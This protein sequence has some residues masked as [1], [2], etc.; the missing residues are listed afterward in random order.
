M[1]L[2]SQLFERKTLMLAILVLARQLAAALAIDLTASMA[3]ICRTLGANR[4]SVYEQL[5]RLLAC[6]GEFAKARPGRPPAT[7]APEP[8]DERAALR[9]TVEVLEYR[10]QHPGA[11]IE[12]R[13]RT[14]YA[15][16]FR[17]FVLQRHD[18]WQGSLQA[19]ADAVQVP[20]DTLRDWR[21]DDHAEALEPQ[22]K[23]RPSVP[24]NASELT[25]QIVDEWM[26]WIGPTRP[27]I[28]YA[29]QYFDLS[30][31]LIAR[32]M[33]ILGLIRPRR[34][35]SGCRYRGSTQT[36]SPATMLVTDGKWLTL[37]LLDS[38]QTLYFNWQGIVDQT[39]G[40][41]TAVVIT[42]QEDATAARQAYER[43]VH[44]LGGLVPDALLHDNKPC[45]DD[46][47]LRQTLALYGTDMI[48]ATLGRAQNK[49]ILE[50]AFGLWQQR[51][52]TLRLD[53]TDDDTLLRSAVAEMVRVYTAATNAVPRLELDG[54]SRLQAL[55]ETCPTA[56][57]RQRDED[58]LAQ[59]KADHR[60]PRR[61]EPLPESLQLIEHVFERFDLA[62]HDP[63]GELRRYL[64]TF[65]TAA[66]RRA[67]AI[68]A[69][70]LDHHLE[71]RFAHRYLAQIIRT[72]QDELDLERAANELLELCQRQHQDWTQGEEKHFQILAEQHRD[73]AALVASVAQRAAFGGLPL[74][75]AFWNRKLLELL[76]Q[77]D[78]LVE[79]VKKNLVRLYEAPKQ[80]RL[81]LLDLITAQQQ[82]IR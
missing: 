79:S 58:F 7:A 72:Q 55:Q 56:E 50:G 10:L 70:K 9:L 38:E 43:S 3:E 34:R 15:D 19:F 63:S 1:T 44:F 21:R 77:A 8:G 67:A 69:A 20:L 80:Q 37:E 13:Q 68:L 17:R 46:A 39:T 23:Q 4:T 27:F 31:A 40:C 73:P 26:H 29:A 74:Q 52:G 51:V 64:A 47:Q 53:D 60:R 41:D 36:L 28:S 30:P 18:H 6:L 42:P 11:V 81:A 75:G 33:K 49:A 16:A 45:Y 76:R 5:Q 22:D 82:G 65:S 57:Q 24:A 32:L 54:R 12:H 2:P 59:L 66:I 14:T 78:H 48:P 25:R 62:A 61:R 35:R 71:H